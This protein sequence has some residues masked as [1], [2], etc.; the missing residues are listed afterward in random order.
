MYQAR[1]EKRPLTCRRLSTHLYAQIQSIE[2]DVT[3]QISATVNGIQS[4]I[5]TTRSEVNLELKLLNDKVGEVTDPK[6]NKCKGNLEIE[7]S[8]LD[9]SFLNECSR[10][11]ELNKLYAQKGSLV[12]LKYAAGAICSECGTEGPLCVAESY[13]EIEIRAKRL[14]LNINRGLTDVQHKS[15]ECI[16]EVKSSTKGIIENA[17]KNFDICLESL[18]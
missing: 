17:S 7:I 10:D 6:A 16:H 8:K 14:R 13:G 2:E 12:E 4:E 18:L 9:E 3:K 11:E 5:Q 15:N 1:E